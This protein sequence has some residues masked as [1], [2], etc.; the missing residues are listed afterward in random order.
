MNRPTAKG[1]WPEF[2]FV[3]DKVTNIWYELLLFNA[4]YRESDD[5]VA[6]LAKGANEFFY[7]YSFTLANS[8]IISLAAI[9]DKKNSGRAQQNIVLQTV[10]DQ[11]RDWCEEATL[12]ECDR[13]LSK[14]REAVGRVFRFRHKK[15][16]HY[17]MDHN[18]GKL[19]A[20]VPYSDLDTLAETASGILN[21]I[22]SDLF[23]SGTGYETPIKHAPGDVLQCIKD[24]LWL[25]E[26]QRMIREGEISAD[27]AMKMAEWDT[28]SG[29]WI[30]WCLSK[31]RPTD[32]YLSI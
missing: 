2:K 20:S 5:T 22:Q 12:A 15:L 24:K 29:E 11:S 9:F 32:Y 23:G 18:I 4:L 1:D 16:A 6:L 10:V 13:Q 14:A 8:L 19:S 7:S 28:R 3:S 17:D 31:S 25:R 30:R 26:F 27:E 21:A